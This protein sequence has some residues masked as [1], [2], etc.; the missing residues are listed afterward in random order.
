MKFKNCTPHA[1][2]LISVDGSTRILEPVWP[3]AR[4]VVIPSSHEEVVDGIAIRGAGR[5]D[6]IEGLP[7]PEDDVVVIVSQITAHFVA[8]TQPDRD[9]VV[10]P[11]SGKIEGAT[12]D[13]DGSLGVRRLVRAR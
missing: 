9:D 8:A 13:S 4:V 2:A 6:G 11:A 5:F 10:Y 12:R 3:P 1:I 7:E